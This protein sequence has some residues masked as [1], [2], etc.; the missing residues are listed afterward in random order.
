MSKMMTI[1]QIAAE[2]GLTEYCVRQLVA[3][4]TLP[5]IRVGKSEKGKILINIDEAWRALERLQ[6]QGVDVGPKPS[7][8]STTSPTNATVP[9]PAR[10]P[11]MLWLAEIGQPII[12]SKLFVE[13]REA[14]TRRQYK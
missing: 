4:N 1:K 9:S 14:I 5:H 11:Y 3:D 8:P 13:H 2:I 7:N 12:G 10:R 6:N